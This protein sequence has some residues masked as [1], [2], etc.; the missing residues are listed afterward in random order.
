MEEAMRE[1]SLSKKKKTSQNLDLDLIPSSSSSDAE[2]RSWSVGSLNF[3]TSTPQKQE[4][5]KGQLFSCATDEGKGKGGLC[6]Y[7]TVKEEEETK[8][9]ASS[10]SS[11][12]RRRKRQQVQ[13]VVSPYFHKEEN[14]FSIT[15]NSPFFKTTP[16]ARK[17]GK[18]EEN[19]FSISLNSPFFKTTPLAGKIDETNKD[20][21]EG[22]TPPFHERVKEENKDGIGVVSPYFQNSAKQE[23][24]DLKVV[25]LSPY[26]NKKPRRRRTTPDKSALLSPS[27]KLDEA[28]RRRTPDNPWNPPRSHFTLLQEEHVHDP[29]RVLLICMLLNRT[30]GLQAGR[31]ISELFSLCPNAKTATQ[32]ATEEIEKVIQTLGLQK[33]RAIMIQRFSWEYLEESWTHVTQLHG[34]GKYAADAYAIFCTGKWERVRPTDHMLNKYW[35]FLC[36]NK[37]SM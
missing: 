7:E 20:D 22:I 23:K 34:V 2:G 3:Q 10:S 18:I 29:W 16:L 37:K 21:D 1:L 27:Q 35:K 11:S 30:S 14:N 6:F 32:V 8:A 33:K 25:V 26:F 4:K 24:E 17:D 13:V 15:L 5:P 36:S 9:A 31:V 19:N 28:Y 12:S